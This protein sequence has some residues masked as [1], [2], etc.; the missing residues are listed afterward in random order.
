MDLKHEVIGVDPAGCAVAW[1]VKG[2]A[3]NANYMNTL[4]EHC[5]V[6]VTL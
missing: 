5:L 3:G 6:H 1:P 2:D 4:R